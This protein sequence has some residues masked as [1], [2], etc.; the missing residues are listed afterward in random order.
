MR[1]WGTVAFSWLPSLSWN[2][3]KANL[4]GWLWI[5]CRARIVPRTNMTAIIMEAT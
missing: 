2:M 5:K 3:I 4:T 1:E